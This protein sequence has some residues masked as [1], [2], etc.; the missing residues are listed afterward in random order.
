MARVV[1]SIASDYGNAVRW[2]KVITKDLAGALRFGELSKQLGRPAPVPSIFIDGKLVFS[3][4][5]G[6]EELREHLDGM[7]AESPELP[8]PTA[9]R[10]A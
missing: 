6:R 5:P 7:L 2:E 8:R 1:E 3:S 4:T 10:C 9:P